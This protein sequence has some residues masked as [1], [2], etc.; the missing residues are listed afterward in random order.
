MIITAL[1]LI[2]IVITI[3]INKKKRRQTFPVEPD[4]LLRVLHAGLVRELVLFAIIMNNDNNDNNIN[5]HH[6]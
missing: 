5:H 6:Y 4:L 3:N 1:T 2:K